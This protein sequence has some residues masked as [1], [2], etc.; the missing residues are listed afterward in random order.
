M[1]DR[2]DVPVSK[3]L[4]NIVN[5]LVDLPEFVIIKN[6][7]AENGMAFA[8]EVHPDDRGKVIGK[9]GRNA[10]S[11]RIILSAVGRKLHRRYS[12]EIDEA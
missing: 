12:I 5:A 9:Q 8:I 7:T 4:H 10:Q 3:L 1:P 6:R 2:R 11:L